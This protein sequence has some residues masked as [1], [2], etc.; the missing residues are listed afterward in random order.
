MKVNGQF[1]HLLPVYICQ[2]TDV[3][4]SAVDPQHWRLSLPTDSLLTVYSLCFVHFY[5]QQREQ[6]G[7]ENSVRWWEEEDQ[8]NKPLG[9]VCKTSAVI[10][11]TMPRPKDYNTL[12]LDYFDCTNTSV[13]ASATP[14]LP[15]LKPVQASYS[16]IRQRYAQFFLF[17][18]RYH[19]G[20]QTTFG[21]INVNKNGCSNVLASFIAAVAKRMA[22][23]THKAHCL[24]STRRICCFA[25][26]VKMQVIFHKQLGSP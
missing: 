25:A 6:H 23:Q 9:N 16:N 8:A 18:K 26:H 19:S 1:H 20:L 2:W 3:A 24:V 17:L 12:I 21:A 22:T 4:P 14:V 10:L 11:V 13:R 15:H 7:N 5:C